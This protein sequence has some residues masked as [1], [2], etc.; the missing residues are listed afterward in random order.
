MRRRNFL[1]AV[2]VASASLVLSP[3]IT[4]AESFTKTIKPKKLQT[5]DTIGLIS[6]GGFI[7]EQQFEEA[8]TNIL[9]LGFSVVAAKNILNRYGYLA[10]TDKERADDL[11]E[12]FGN[13]KIDGIVCVRGGYGCARVLDFLD[14]NLIKN[15]PKILIGYSDITALLYGIF[16][17][18][19]LIGFHGPV[20][21][22]T[23]NEFSVNNFKNVLMNPQKQI[24]LQSAVEDAIKN[25]YKPFVIRSGKAKGKLVGGNLSIVASLIGTKY[26]VDTKGKIIFLEEVGEEP[27]RVDRMLTQ[28]IQA[29]KFKHASGVALGVFTKCESKP[30]QSGIANS[31]S[32]PEVLR[33]RLFQLRI[34]VLYGLSFGHVVNKFTLPFGINVALDVDNQKLTLLEKAVV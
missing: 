18:T 12:M 30:D 10:G 24:S 26:D 33:E 28:M 6:P 4:F 8:K 1:S 14:F 16:S 34:P 20:A 32:L 22:S 21:T 2:G 27:Y 23:F 15:N 13:K 3:R 25:E 17:Q 29:G 19:G 31:F 5:G 7:T 9:S 11:H